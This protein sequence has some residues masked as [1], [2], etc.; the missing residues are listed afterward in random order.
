MAKGSTRITRPAAIEAART[1]ALGA[2]D[3]YDAASAADKPR[4]RA[5]LRAAIDKLAGIPPI[6]P[7]PPQSLET[8]VR[9]VAQQNPYTS[10]A[11]DDMDLHVGTPHQGN[12]L[13]IPGFPQGY[14]PPQGDDSQIEVELD[15]NY[16][17]TWDF[18]G[19]PQKISKVLRIKY[20]CKALKKHAAHTPNPAVDVPYWMTAY[21]LIGFEDGM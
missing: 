18:K 20:R 11:V 1:E 2:L 8:L 21:L 10:G 19:V 14:R 15:G 4:T 3:G 7:I 16:P 5:A 6:P 12:S 13:P 17:G 9:I